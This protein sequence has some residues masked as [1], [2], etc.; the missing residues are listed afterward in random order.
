MSKEGVVAL[1][2]K[3]L[4]DEAFKAQLKAN[5]KEALSQFDLTEE[6]IKAI[7][8]G[9]EEQLKALGLDERLSKSVFGGGLGITFS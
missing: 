3:A 2:E 7:A 4:S 1:I 5:S 6:E 8:G 9:S